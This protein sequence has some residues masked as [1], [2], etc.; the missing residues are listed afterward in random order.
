MNFS[1]EDVARILAPVKLPEASGDWVSAREAIAIVEQIT[2]VER[3]AAIQALCRRAVFP[4]AVSASVCSRGEDP[5]EYINR[6]EFFRDREIDLSHFQRTIAH[7]SFEEISGFFEVLENSETPERDYRILHAC[8]A[9][10]DFK[11]RVELDFSDVTLTVAGLRFDRVALQRSLG[12]GF[13]QECATISEVRNQGG[14]P[15]RKHGEAISA[16]TI[17]LAALSSAE[18]AC[19]TAEAVGAELADEYVKL[20]ERAPHSGNLATFGA[21]I[22][23]T[24][25]QRPRA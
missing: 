25:R 7:S 1:D 19:Y 6:C 2:G 23:R 12:V 24:L 18:L 21:G 9:T 3:Q 11:V 10:G 20:G 15:A 4:V 13:E 16:V 5:H 22:L 8:W 17:R 14:R